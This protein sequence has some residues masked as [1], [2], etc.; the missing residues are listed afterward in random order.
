MELTASTMVL[1]EM[2]EVSKVLSEYMRFLAI[3]FTPKMLSVTNSP[4][5]HSS[6]GGK[7]TIQFLSFQEPLLIFSHLPRKMLTPHIQYIRRDWICKIW[8]LVDTRKT[9][10]IGTCPG[11]CR[12]TLHQIV[13]V[14]GD[15]SG[16]NA[17]DAGRMLGP[18]AFVLLGILPW[19]VSKTHPPHSTE[20]FK[21]SYLLPHLPLKLFL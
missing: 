2:A 15:T 5:K 4:H 13:E 6:L 18:T 19:Q 21:N 10:D 17:E 3:I 1:I 9:G 11:A 16:E 12:D 8:K 7:S 20:N 14:C